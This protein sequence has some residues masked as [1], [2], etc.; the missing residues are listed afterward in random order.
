MFSFVP[1]VQALVGAAGCAARAPT[2]GA[3][4]APLSALALPD[5]HDNDNND[6]NKAETAADKHGAFSF[7]VD[8]KRVACTCIRPQ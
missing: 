4:A 5:H 1:E 2:R 8:R 3:V 7:P 6:D